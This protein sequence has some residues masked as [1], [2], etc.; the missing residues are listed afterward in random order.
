MIGATSNIID[1]KY[2]L[3]GSSADLTNVFGDIYASGTNVYHSRQFQFDAGLNFDLSSVLK[4]LSFHTMVAIDYATAYSTSFNNSYATFQLHGLT[5]TARMYRRFEQQ[6]Y[7]GQ[8]IGS[9]EYLWFY[10]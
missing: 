4:G 7:G 1:G 8:E 2:F 10:R 5:S 3:G 9:S 6:W